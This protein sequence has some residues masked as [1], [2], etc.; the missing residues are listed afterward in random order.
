MSVID[1]VLEYR[2]EASDSARSR[3]NSAI[4]DSVSLQGFRD[5]SIAQ[6]QQLRDPV[7]AEIILGQDR[8]AGAILRTWVE[9]QEDLRAVVT[10]CLSG[11]GVSVEGPDFQRGM[12]EST[13]L[14]HE[15]AAESDLIASEESSS[16]FDADDIALMLC[17]VS[18]RIPVEETLVEMESP[19][20]QEW[21]D[22]LSELPPD[23]PEWDH[24]EEFASSLVGLAHAKITERR[25]V[26]IE[27]ITGSVAE[28]KEE[29]DDE[30]GYLEI[31]LIAWSADDT[32]VSDL[33]EAALERLADLESALAEY[34]QIRPQAATRAEELERAGQRAEYETIIFDLAERW[35]ELMNV[36]DDPIDETESHD[37]HDEAGDEISPVPDELGVDSAPTA[38][39][40]TVQT[41]PVTMRELD[42]LI[43]DNES[44][45]S[46]NE[47]LRQD[48]DGLQEDQSLLTEENG[49]LKLE[50]SESRAAEE[51]WR[52]QYVYASTTRS[53]EQDIE[54][55]PP[56]NVREAIERAEAAFSN[57]LHFAL[58]SKSE[59][60]S[61]FQRPE[62]VLN[63]LGW[64]ATEYHHH[65]SSPARNFRP[66]FDKLIKESC[67]GWTYKPK[68]TEVTLDQFREWY[69]TTAYG[70]SY[71]L[72]AHIGRGNSFDPHHTIRIAFDWDAEHQKVIIGYIG[73]H[74]RNRRS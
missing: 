18:G 36:P 72:N 46:E 4:K 5:A 61:Q 3:L 7:L 50:L 57:K 48:S 51:Y 74:Q 10:E 40:D 68:Q 41:D 29:F 70:K 58:N 32:A 33:I 16:L 53:L 54:S 17:C 31:D 1:C 38:D 66:N 39:V 15:W 19:R 9:S 44:L 35:E 59:R 55:D 11:R 24:A 65:R 56:R 6:R 49:R 37:S 20:F 67:P 2:A 69:T 12:F 22:E 23:A 71:E 60:S 21:L 62:D 13:W 45:N 73:R 34:S 25:T 27:T 14:R 30:L 28:I 8:L 42:R 26:Q 64:L 43:Q 63:A 47:R 52:Q